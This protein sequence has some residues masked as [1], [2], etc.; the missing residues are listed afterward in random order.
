MLRARNTVSQEHLQLSAQRPIRVQH[1]RVTAA[2]VAPHD[3][4]FY[5]LVL[6]RAGSA[7]H[8]TCD[9]RR[10]ISAGDFLIL[11]PGQ[12]HALEQISKLEVANV[13]YLPQWVLRDPWLIREAPRLCM[14]FL[15]AHLFPDKI[16]AS[17]LQV[18]L[19]VTLATQLAAEL[20]F[21]KDLPADGVENSILARGSLLKCFAWTDA[22][23]ASQRTIAFE[24]LQE[25]LVRHLLDCMERAIVDGQPCSLDAWAHS[26]G[27]SADHLSRVFLQRTGE[28]PT[29]FFQRRRLLHAEHALIYADESIS[30]IAHRLG[31]ADSAHLSRQFRAAQGITPLAYRK[32][33]RVP[34]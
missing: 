4:E 1:L 31:F 14:R 7:C 5:E 29:A 6:V 2:S 8:H 25:P 28:R 13:Y 20:E 11:A 3:H 18:T 30:Q 21:L 27:C 12:V 16:S 26:T 15:G 24:F 19:P 33:F 10:R 23:I 34:A 32:R 9:G 22:A 17:P